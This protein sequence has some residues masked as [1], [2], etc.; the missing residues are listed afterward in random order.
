MA[1]ASCSQLDARRADAGAGGADDRRAGRAR[2]RAAARR[3]TSTASRAASRST[4]FRRRASPT[5]AARCSIAAFSSKKASR[6]REREIER[7]VER[8]VAAAPGVRFDLR[9]LMV[10]HPT[11]TPGRLA[12]DRRARAQ[13]SG[14]CS[15]GPRELIA[16]P[17]T[18][19]HKHVARIAGVAALRRVRAGRVSSSR[20]SR[21]SACRIDDS[22]TRRRSSRSRRST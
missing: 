17:G 1:W 22:S 4:A 10:V 12:G 16:S 3:S 6:P 20:I 19:D 15:G 9:D 5:C 8:A 21:T 18:Y 14:A 11:R 13:R 2:R 7:L